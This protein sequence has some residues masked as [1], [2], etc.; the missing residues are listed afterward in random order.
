MKRRSVTEYWPAAAKVIEFG[1]RDCGIREQLTAAGFRYLGVVGSRQRLQRIVS[2]QPYL[3]PQLVV[4][5]SSQGIR[6]NNA[7]VLILQGGAAAKLGRYRIIRHAK[8]IACPLHNGPVLLW[9][10]LFWLGHFLLGRLAWPRIVRIGKVRLLS[11]RVRRPKPHEST[12]RFIPHETG[13]EGFFAQVK[14]ANIRHAVLRWFDDLPQVASGEDLALLVDDSALD[15]VR[16]LLDSGP[17]I[18]AVDLYSVYGSPGADFRKLPI[19][20]STTKAMRPACHSPR[21]HIQK[22]LGR[23]TITRRSSRRW[24]LD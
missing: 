9:T 18:Q 19:T 16:E 5:P 13:V 11:F 14:S 17:G 8:Y 24:P 7:D 20:R 2:G 3:M 4:S 23:S 6:S 21:S 12:R 1:P 10:M 15:T 22:S